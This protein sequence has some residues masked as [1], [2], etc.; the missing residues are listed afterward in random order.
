MFFMLRCDVFLWFQ[1]VLLG[2]IFPQ[3]FS[4]DHPLK[5]NGSEK[6]QDIWGHLFGQT[7]PDLLNLS[8]SSQ[9]HLGSHK[10]LKKKHI[11]QKELQIF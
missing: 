7:Y 5:A 1:P 9:N 8:K 3:V 10:V 11:P 4:V 2:L 6:P